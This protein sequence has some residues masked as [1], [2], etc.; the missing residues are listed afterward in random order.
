MIKTDI[1]PEFAL[2][3]NRA[4]AESYGSML[5]LVAPK[6]QPPSSLSLTQTVQTHTHPFLLERLRHFRE[7]EEGSLQGF[8]GTAQA[9]VTQLLWEGQRNI[10]YFAATGAQ[11]S[12]LFHTSRPLTSSRFRENHARAP[13][14]LTRNSQVHPLVFTDAVHARAVSLALQTP[15]HDLRDV[16]PSNIS[17]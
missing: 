5:A 1:L 12:S 14:W 3:V 9:E 17:G 11:P 16:D 10:G 13:D 2:H 15:L 8:T 6:S 7:A 4:I